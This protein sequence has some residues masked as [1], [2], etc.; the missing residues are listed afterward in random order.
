MILV[1]WKL[2]AAAWAAAVARWRRERRSSS[3]EDEDVRYLAAAL[4]DFRRV[5]ACGQPADIAA[6][7]ALARRMRTGRGSLDFVAHCRWSLRLMP[8]WRRVLFRPKRWPWPSWRRVSAATAA[9]LAVL[10][11][12]RCAFMSVRL[13]AAAARRLWPALIIRSWP[14]TGPPLVLTP[15]LEAAMSP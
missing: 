5:A 11:R 10:A 13:R 4:S 15:A 8:G 2:W 3:R 6:S 14:P 9:A 7:R 12:L 1:V